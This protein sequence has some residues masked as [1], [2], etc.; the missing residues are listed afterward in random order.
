MA[1]FGLFDKTAKFTKQVNI[2]GFHWQPVL[3]VFHLQ[4]G[5]NINAVFD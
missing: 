2:N 1:C 5:R 3:S 4:L